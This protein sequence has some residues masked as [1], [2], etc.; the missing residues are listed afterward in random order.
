MQFETWSRISL[1]QCVW[2]SLL[3]P[4]FELLLSVVG[5]S[6][7]VSLAEYALKKIVAMK[8]MLTTLSVSHENGQNSHRFCPFAETFVR[9]LDEWLLQSLRSGEREVEQSAQFFSSP[10]TT[11]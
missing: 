8:L 6:I 5:L 1:D 11:E 7:G 10:A 3:P 4:S 2:E 9:C